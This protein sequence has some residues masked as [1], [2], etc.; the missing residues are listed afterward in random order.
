MTTP[1]SARPPAPRMR[2]ATAPRRTPPSQTPSMAKERS[3]PLVRLVAGMVVL[4]V[5]FAGGAYLYVHVAGGLFARSQHLPAP[6]LLALAL[7]GGA[8]SFFSPCSIAVTPSFIGYLSGAGGQSAGG[9]RRLVGPAALVAAGIVAFYAAAGAAVGGIGS[10]V[11]NYLVYLVLVIGVV[12]MVLGYLLLTGRGDALV[13]LGNLNPA[14]RY[15]EASMAATTSGHPRAR[16]VGFGVAYGAA[17]HTCTLPIFLGIVLAPIAA[18]DFA[19]A[20]GATLLY[21]LAIAALLIVMAVVGEGALSG[22]RRR[23]LGHYLGLL[24][25]GLFVLTGGY[26]LYYFVTNYGGFL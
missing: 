17:S 1:P 26:L 14:N 13:R 25:G 20:G 2:P 15:Y 24:T 11:Y 19:L 16:L 5:L 12:F 8:A 3:S 6:L 10:V 9:R 7:V 18:G 4:A 23:M 22:I 21:G